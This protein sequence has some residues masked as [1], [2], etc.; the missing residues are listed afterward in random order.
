[1]LV[2]SVYCGGGRAPEPRPCGGGWSRWNG[3]IGDSRSRFPPPP[4]HPDTHTVAQLT[5]MTLSAG[6]GVI[7]VEGGVNGKRPP[8]YMPHSTSP[9]LLGEPFNTGCR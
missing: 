2:C 5:P 6:G 9:Q 7:W 1:M 8:D 4:P 3:A